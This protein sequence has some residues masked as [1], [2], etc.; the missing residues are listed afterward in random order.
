MDDRTYNSG[1]HSA[2]SG[3]VY[4]QKSAQSQYGYNVYGLW[5]YGYMGFIRVLAATNQL[6]HIT[7]LFYE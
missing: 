3:G 6:Y 1:V 4:M 5:V 2:H 7:Y